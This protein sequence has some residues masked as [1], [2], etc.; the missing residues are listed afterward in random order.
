MTSNEEYDFEENGTI[1]GQNVTQWDSERIKHGKRPIGVPELDGQLGGVPPGSVVGL[2]MEPKSAGDII[3]YHLASTAPSAYITTLRREN[4]IEREF[5]R[6]GPTD[7][8]PPYTDII[9]TRRGNDKAK[10]KIQSVLRRADGTK[11]YV[12]DAINGASSSGEISSI[13][14]Q[15]SINMEEKDGVALVIFLQDPNGSMDE[16]MK[17]ALYHCDI[18]MNNYHER[19]ANDSISHILE[20]SRFRGSNT[21][22][23]EN[24]YRL[25]IDNCCSLDGQNTANV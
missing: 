17:Q 6:F 7:G 4:I 22:I 14:S 24:T 10:D 21:R 8:V 13:M 1:A 16:E 18:V 23:P 2:V 15:V 3:A 19:A 25:E 20:V 5:D 12:I 9:S 11:N